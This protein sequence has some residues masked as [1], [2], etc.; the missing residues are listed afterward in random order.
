M[1]F[2]GPPGCGKTET[3][4]D[5]CQHN[6]GRPVHRYVAQAVYRL[7]VYFDSAR[8]MIESNLNR[9][10]PEPLRLAIRLSRCSQELSQ[11]KR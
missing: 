9:Q 8:A 4:I 1:S 10:H 2:R 3:M 11:S 7:W 6:F 5:I